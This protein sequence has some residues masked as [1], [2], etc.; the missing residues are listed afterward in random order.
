MP[1]PINFL[2]R[3]VANLTKCNECGQQFPTI[4]DRLQHA[5]DA[6]SYQKVGAQVFKRKLCACGKPGLYR[7]GGSVYC[8]EH[9]GLAVNRRTVAAQWLDGLA[10]ERSC[11]IEAKDKLWYQSQRHHAARGSRRATS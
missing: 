6:H 5:I 9:Q 11:D 7:V 3:T 1:N 2:P 8:R 4:G 10:S